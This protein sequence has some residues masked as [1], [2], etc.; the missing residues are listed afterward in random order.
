MRILFTAV[1]AV[2]M[3]AACDMPG[4]EKA[5]TPAAPAAAAP[6]PAPAAEP[7]APAGPSAS[8]LERERLAKMQNAAADVATFTSICASDSNPK[9]DASVCECVGKNTEKTLGAQGLFTWV[10]EGYVNRTGTAQMRAKKW[11]TDNSIDT[12]AQKKFVDAIG[13]CYVTQ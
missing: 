12:A 6:A 3:L 5:E 1:A 7:A 10:W 4:A 2:A 8:D 13:T 9:I 11:F